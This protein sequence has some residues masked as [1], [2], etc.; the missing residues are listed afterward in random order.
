MRMQRQFTLFPL[1]AYKRPEA[2]NVIKS[3]LIIQ[4]NAL[5][6]LPGRL[7]SPHCDMSQFFKL[8]KPSIPSGSTVKLLL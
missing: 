5:A 7:V 3:I 4:D 6:Y 8:S 2:F 1:C